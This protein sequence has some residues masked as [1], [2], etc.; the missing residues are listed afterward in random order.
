MTITFLDLYNECAGQPWSMYD[1]DAE[2]M[3]DLES[4]LRISI[5]KACSYLWN[6]Q[7]WSFRKK[8]TTIITDEG[9]ADYDLPIGLIQRKT[10]SGTQ[11]YGVKYNGK[12]LPYIQDY[13]EAD[14]RTGEPEYFYIDGDK[15]YIYPTPDDAYTVT[16]NY[17]SLTYAL[18]EDEE[19]VYSF[20]SDTDTLNVPEQYEQL[21]SNCLI[22]LAMLYAIAD[23][24]DENYSG[25]QKQYEDALAILIKYCNT[26]INDRSFVW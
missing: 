2:G 24:T 25:Y 22:S 11:K 9:K 10:I 20:T 26:A 19:D 5:N 4:A 21:F 17:L 14:D 1:N 6:Y 23:E 13:E 16:L 3:D 7:P 8:S 18:N 15:L 12:F